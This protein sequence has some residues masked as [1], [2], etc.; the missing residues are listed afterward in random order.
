M[1]YT[2]EYAYADWCVSQLAKQLNKPADGKKYAHRGEAYKNIFDAEKGWFRPK[3]KD[4]NWL[5]W[6]D[7]ARLKQW[8]GTIESNPY[9]Q[10]WFVPQDVDGMAKLMGGRGKTIADLNS[11]FEKTP[12]NMMWNDYYNHANE[13]VHHVPF[14]YNRLGAPWLT[15]RW[16]RE[17]CRR[18]YKN[19]VEGLVGNEDVGQMSA[20]YVLAASGIHPVCPGDTRQEIT[21]P[22]FN[23]ITFKLDP[24]YAAGKTF[25]II[26][27]NNSAQNSYIQSAKLNG[28]LYN[29]CYIDYKDIAAGGILELTMGSTP[30]KSWGIN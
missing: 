10:G 21:S 1:S 28:K 3:D 15:Q 8:Y 23:K 5:P 17:I 26:A 6:P 13:P 14:L 29:K 16:T 18:A 4:G 25:S 7:S 9:Q 11:L 22:V 19:S 24:E 12:D 30:N 20:W 2:L 27:K